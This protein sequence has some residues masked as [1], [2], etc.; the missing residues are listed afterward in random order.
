MTDDTREAAARQLLAEVQKLLETDPNNAHLR[1]E[2]M[3][4]EGTVTAYAF[5]R[6]LASGL[7]LLRRL[8][9]AQGTWNRRN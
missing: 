2:E 3:R 9:L 7:D 1:S 8:H 4:L 6:K 5:N